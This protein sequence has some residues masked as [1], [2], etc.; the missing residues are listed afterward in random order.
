M[1]TDGTM[2]YPSKTNYFNMGGY[3][4]NK[5][6]SI[7]YIENGNYFKLANVKTSTF[8]LEMK[9]ELATDEKFPLKY[10]RTTDGGIHNENDQYF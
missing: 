10:T 7:G 4:N 6:E 2:H 1:Q 3:V 8:S 5:V 9:K